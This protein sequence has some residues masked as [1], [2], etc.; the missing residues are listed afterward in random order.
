MT[1]HRGEHPRMGATDVCPF[2]PVSGVTMEECAAIAHALGERCRAELGIPGY[3]YESA[4]K[5]PSAKTSRTA[6]KGNT[7]AWPNWKLRKERL[8]LDRR[9]E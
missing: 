3:F 2:V 5:T 1:K 9:R 8:I 4:A 6:A 7:K